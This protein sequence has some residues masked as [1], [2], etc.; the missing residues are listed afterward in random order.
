MKKEDVVDDL[1]ED[2]NCG[3]DCNDV[4]ENWSVW[5]E[6]SIT[7][8]LWK[9]ESENSYTGFLYNVAINHFLTEEPMQMITTMTAVWDEEPLTAIRNAAES[10]SNVYDDIRD[11]ILVFDVDDG[12][13]IDHEEYTITEAFDDLVEEEETIDKL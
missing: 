3:C 12:E 2:E 6:P 4:I 13:P 8:S 1:C 7:L 11:H 9:H 5:G 10:L